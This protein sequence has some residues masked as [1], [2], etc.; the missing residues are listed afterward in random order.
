MLK[1]NY[2]VF[3][4]GLANRTLFQMCG[5]LYLPM[6][7]LLVGLF[8]LIHLASLMA[9]AILWPSLAMIL[10]FSIVVLWPVMFWCSKMGDGA[11]K[12][13]LYLSSKV[14]AGSI[15]D[16]S[17]HSVL[18]HLNQYMMLLWFVMASLSLGTS[19]DFSK[20]SLL[21]NVPGHHICHKFLVALTWAL[22]IRYHYV[23]S[24]VCLAGVVAVLFSSIPF[25][26]VF[27]LLQNFIYCPI[28]IFALRKDLLKMF[29]FLLQQFR[30]GAHCFVPVCEGV[31]HTVFTSQVV[32]DVPLKV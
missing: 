14:L 1:C 16:S 25:V 15:I 13:S 7:L 12:C 18:P 17:S 31:N 30:V 29:Q 19:T 3:S 22:W 26:F 2:L 20:C 8:T 10:K 23:T 11:F 4:S 9:L 5:R 32:V 6:F 27:L 28:W 21:W 24:L